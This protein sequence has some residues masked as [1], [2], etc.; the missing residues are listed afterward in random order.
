MVN[1][2]RKRFFLLLVV[3]FLLL[4][5][6][7]LTLQ[8]TRI[9]S[10]FD[11]NGEYNI[12]AAFSTILLLS[13][14][15]S[16]WKAAVRIKKSGDVKLRMFLAVFG[17]LYLFFAVDELIGIHEFLGVQCRVK[18]LI[19]YLPFCIICC[20]F[21]FNWFWLNRNRYGSLFF[22]LTL[23]LLISI[24]GAFGCEALNSLLFP[25]PPVLQQLEYMIEEGLEM[26]GSV[27]VLSGIW[28]FL[29]KYNQNDK[30]GQTLIRDLFQYPIH[31]PTI[32]L[33]PVPFG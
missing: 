29:E 23:G 11:L 9:F 24:C 25:L 16:S 4:A 27:V 5:L 8:N 19:I 28:N 3:L 14:A 12:P 17:L 7:P 33:V 20:G 15:M 13:V 22:R 32:H 2:Y 1:S 18:W 6:H 30:P 21:M 31:N 10:W 26:L